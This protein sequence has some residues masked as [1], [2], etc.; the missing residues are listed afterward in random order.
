MS[1]KTLEK[2]PHMQRSLLPRAE[3][4]CKHTVIPRMASEMGGL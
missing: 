3:P 2:E 4:W 1:L